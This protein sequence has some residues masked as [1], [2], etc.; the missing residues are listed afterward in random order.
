MNGLGNLSRF[1][2][3]GCVADNT[4]NRY[5]FALRRRMASGIPG[6]SSLLQI[7]HGARAAPQSQASSP[8][9]GRSG[10]ALQTH[11][12][13]SQ[14]QQIIR[15]CGMAYLCAPDSHRMQK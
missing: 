11:M 3:C 10:W 4:P 13:P 5:L 1:S 12:Q 14:R 8:T 15:G 9:H 2:L 7:G 6:G